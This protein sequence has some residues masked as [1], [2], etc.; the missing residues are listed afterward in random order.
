MTTEWIFLVKILLH[1]VIEDY[2][3]ADKYLQAGSICN[4]RC[5]LAGGDTIPILGINLNF[6]YLKITFI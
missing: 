2:C 1:L 6:R 4:T 5:V 3:E